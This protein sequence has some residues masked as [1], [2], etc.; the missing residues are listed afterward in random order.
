MPDKVKHTKS[1]HVSGRTGLKSHYPQT[2]RTCST[3]ELSQQVIK[4][5]RTT[6]EELQVSLVSVK[7]SVHVV[8]DLFMPVL[9]SDVSIDFVC[10]HG[11]SWSPG[12]VLVNS[13]HQKAYFP[14]TSA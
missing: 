11:H 14:S 12:Q 1:C 8:E 2:E 6:S 10:F 13:L 4:E 3:G 9:V 5:P 7:I